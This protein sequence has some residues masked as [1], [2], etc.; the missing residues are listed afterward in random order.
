MK[1]IKVEIGRKRYVVYID[2]DDNK[3]IKEFTKALKKQFAWWKFWNK[4]IIV[5]DGT[6]RFEKL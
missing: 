2:T 6:V 4:F 5:P 1:K 3:K